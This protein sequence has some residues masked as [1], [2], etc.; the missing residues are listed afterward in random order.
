MSLI[1][2]RSKPLSAL[3]HYFG[4]LAALRQ[5]VDYFCVA[6]EFVAGV[7]EGPRGVH[8]PKTRAVFTD[9]P[10][11]VPA[12][13]PGQGLRELA[14]GLSCAYVFGGEKHAKVP[15]YGFA[16]SVAKKRFSSDVPTHDQTIG[17]DYENGVFFE[18][19][20][21]QMV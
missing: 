17:I 11:V 3:T 7:V 18:A 1:D 10:A 2:E 14:L 12:N 20:D 13:G 8:S 19:L 21:E 9:V 4:Y 15:A 16:R 6:Q 5:V